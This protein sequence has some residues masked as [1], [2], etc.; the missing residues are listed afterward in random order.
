LIRRVLEICKRAGGSRKDVLHKVTIERLPEE[1]QR[2]GL[3]AFERIGEDRLT[4]VER[5]VAALFEVT[6]M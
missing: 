2:L 5:R 4:T 3:D 1:V 6:V